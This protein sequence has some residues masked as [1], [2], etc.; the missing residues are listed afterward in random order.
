M[1]GRSGLSAAKEMMNSRVQVTWSS[2]NLAM[3]PR[4]AIS[5]LDS[6]VALGVWRAAAVAMLRTRRLDRPSVPRTRTRERS[7]MPAT[8]ALA[9]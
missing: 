4:K 6:G 7:D 1:T 2:H 9:S 8:V 3:A 5:W